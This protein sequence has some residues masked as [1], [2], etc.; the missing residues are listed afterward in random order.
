MSNQLRQKYG[1]THKEPPALEIT[2]MIGCPLMCSFC[3]QKNLRNSYGKTQDKYMS[4]DTFKK[5]LSKI[6]KNTQIDF[7]GMSEPWANPNCTDMLEHA[8]KENFKVA[9]FTTLW[10]IKLNEINRIIN[11]LETYNSQILTLCI[12]LPDINGNMK[13]WSYTGEWEIIYKKII[14]T[15]LSC[16]VG[17]MTMDKISRVHPSISHFAKPT[18]QAHLHTRA[19]SLDVEQVKGQPVDLGLKHNSKITCKSTPFYDR[20]VLLPNGD[21]VLCCMDYNLKHIIGN[22][23]DSSYEEIFNT[24]ETLLK[25]IEIN[26]SEGYSKCSICKSCY[27]VTYI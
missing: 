7:S 27:N 21:L 12:H 11:L 23:L 2:T 16:G 17:A 9:I 25:L 10:G 20:N 19:D 3:P 18:Y 5:A 4:I 14:N 6:P 8:L 22:I 13:G 15:K 1:I 26:E 24:S